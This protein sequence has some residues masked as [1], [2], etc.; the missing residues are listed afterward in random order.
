MHM[1]QL[2]SVEIPSPELY[3]LSLYP[4]SERAVSLTEDG[5]KYVVALR[6]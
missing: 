2:D 3:R 6:A 1:F 4:L 5:A